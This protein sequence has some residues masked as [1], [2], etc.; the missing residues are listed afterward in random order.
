M[1]QHFSL[2]HIH[3]QGNGGGLIIYDDLPGDGPK[4]W[5]GNR[6][7]DTEEENRKKWAGRAN[8]T[9]PYRQNRMVLF[10]SGRY[11]R[12]AAYNFKPGYRNRRIN[13]TFLFGPAP[14]SQ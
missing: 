6:A 7:R 9:V 1:E 5:L 10:D 14:N 13:L 8:I 2:D 3:R 4:G 11:H 12:S